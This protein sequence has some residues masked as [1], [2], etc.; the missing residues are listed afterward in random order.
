MEAPPT[1]YL[2]NGAAIRR[3]RMDAELEIGALAS[4]AGITASYLSRLEVGTRKRMK[5][6]TYKALRNAL[7]ATNKQLLAPSEDATESR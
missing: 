5:I 3:L 2:V 1:T 6:R 4:E 7:R